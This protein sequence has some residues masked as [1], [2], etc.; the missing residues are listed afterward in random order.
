MQPR[1]HLSICPPNRYS[2]SPYYM[3][4]WPRHGNI[5]DIKTGHFFMELTA[6]WRRQTNNIHSTGRGWEYTDI[7]T[8]TEVQVQHSHHPPTIIF[9]IQ[10]FVFLLHA[11]KSPLTL[12][13]WDRSRDSP[14]EKNHI[15]MLTVLTADLPFLISGAIFCKLKPSNLSLAYNKLRLPCTAVAYFTILHSRLLWE[16][17]CF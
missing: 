5:G 10:S 9:N 13:I 2:W 14:F 1:P 16:C 11:P 6:L 8:R 7:W 4:V 3:R 15:N 17:W 12:D